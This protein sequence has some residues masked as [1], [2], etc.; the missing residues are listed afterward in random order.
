MHDVTSRRDWDRHLAL[1]ASDMRHAARNMPTPQAQQASSDE[2]DTESEL[3]AI[4]HQFPEPGEFPEPEGLLEFQDGSVLDLEIHE[5]ELTYM[6]EESPKGSLSEGEMSAPESPWL[7]SSSGSEKPATRARRLE[8]VSLSSSESRKESGE[9]E[10]EFN[11]MALD[12]KQEDDEQEDDK[13]EDNM[14]HDN[15]DFLAHPE[16]VGDEL[17]QME[18]NNIESSSSSGLEPFLALID[19][20]DN[21]SSSSS[22]A[23][24]LVGQMKRGF[25]S[26]NI[27]SEHGESST[28]PIDDNEE[29]FSDEA[30][31][32]T[33]EDDML[34]HTATLDD[35]EST[36][37]FNYRNPHGEP[38]TRQETISFALDDI[39]Q[40]H[41]IARE[42]ASDI[43]ELFGG[44][45]TEGLLDYRTTRRRIEQ[46]TGVK[47][48][49]YDCCPHSHMSYAMYPDLVSCTHC[50]HPRWKEQNPNGK[51]Q[52]EPKKIPY[53]T[54]S[55][56]PVTHRV[57]LWYT[58]AQKAAM[59]TNYRFQAEKDREK[60]LRSD[61]WSGDL[62]E[63]M[64][65]K[66]GLFDLDTDIG[67]MLSTDGVKV[68][69]SRRSFSIWPLLLVFA[70]HYWLIK[71][72]FNHPNR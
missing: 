54:H 33:Y 13:Q 59:M 22:T 50:S 24:A 8:S 21:A 39:I 55:Y 2:D 44:I 19:I 37:D 4:E 7:G 17:Q 60:D 31:N 18:F 71:A 70:L 46:K 10:P 61:Y 36:M 27:H 30:L 69:K 6:E 5:A 3:E 47:E 64:K 11:F 40:K 23:S 1:K 9:D 45:Y 41:K 42:A 53:A 32:G 51:N 58:D 67:F 14:I 56:I 62:F 34:L 20:N 66:K 26:I 72:K 35:D 38:P 25:V 12:D 63:D 57:R 43:R 49:Q 52:L 28:S 16:I 15:L 29:D 65:T 68:F 48:I